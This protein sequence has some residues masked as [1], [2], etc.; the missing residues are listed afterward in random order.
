M[1]NFTFFLYNQTDS[2]LGGGSNFID[3]ELHYFNF[4]YIMFIVK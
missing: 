2:F 1:K 4:L 3:L